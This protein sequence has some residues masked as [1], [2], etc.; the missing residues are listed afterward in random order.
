MINI[1]TVSNVAKVFTF[2]ALQIT[3]LSFVMTTVAMFDM[4][5]LFY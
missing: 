5:V 1:H 3:S 4:P 2:T